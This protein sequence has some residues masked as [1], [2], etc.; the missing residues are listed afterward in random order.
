MHCTIRQSEFLFHLLLQLFHKPKCSA[1]AVLRRLL[2][3]CRMLHSRRSASAPCFVCHQAN[4]A[5]TYHR[6][7]G[8][9]HN[10]KRLHLV[11]HR[12]HLH[13]VTS[14]CGG[15][16]KLDS[17]GSLRNGGADDRYFPNESPV[18]KVFSLDP[19]HTG[20]FDRFRDR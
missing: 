15:R 18:V 17:E 8:S 2:G 10:L 13:L 1:P 7:A 6:V 11:H 16:K 9:L 3:C 12:Y 14:G 20:I 5:D 19:F 4:N